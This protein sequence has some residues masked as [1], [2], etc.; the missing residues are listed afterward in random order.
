MIKRYKVAQDFL[1]PTG[2]KLL[3][4]DII[5]ED[6]TVLTAIEIKSLRGLKVLNDLASSKKVRLRYDNKIS[7]LKGDS[8]VRFGSLWTAKRDI[9][10]KKGYIKNTW[11]DDWYEDLRGEEIK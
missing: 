9:P 11:Y 5:E 1:L 10:R 8:V 7:Y 2:V 4:D 3:K 6:S